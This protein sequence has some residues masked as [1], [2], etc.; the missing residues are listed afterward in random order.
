MISNLQNLQAVPETVT[1]WVHPKIDGILVFLKWD[2]ET[3]TGKSAK[4]RIDVTKQLWELENSLRDM[5]TAS[6][7]SWAE[8][9]T[10]DGSVN[11]YELTEA[12][13]KSRGVHKNA[14]SLKAYL[15]YP[16]CIPLTDYN[17]ITQTIKRHKNPIEI[18]VKSLKE[19][20]KNAL[21][22]QRGLEGFVIQTPE[23]ILYKWVNEYQLEGKVK[24]CKKEADVYMLEV[25]YESDGKNK[26]ASLVSEKPY[27]VGS[28]VGIKYLNW[29][30]NGTL[31]KPR[32]V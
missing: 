20:F 19:L 6:F 5:R 24:Q 18:T 28:T 3:L 23:G 22:W 26:K 7:S 9:Y 14:S 16:E 1:G 10:G 2:G 8:L 27:K 4:K 21:G 32:I 29:S 12:I 30:S 15:L 25:E 31:R 11:T 13:L 17:V